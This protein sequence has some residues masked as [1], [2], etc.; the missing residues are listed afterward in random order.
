MHTQNVK[1]SCGTQI[2]PFFAGW[3]GDPGSFTLKTPGF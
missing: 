1:I 2:W 3:A